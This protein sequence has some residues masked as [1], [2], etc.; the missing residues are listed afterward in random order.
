M[1]L[2]GE[3]RS[4]CCTVATSSFIFHDPRD[5]SAPTKDLVSVKWTEQKGFVIVEWIG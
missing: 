5:T 2:A 3:R 4:N 1:I